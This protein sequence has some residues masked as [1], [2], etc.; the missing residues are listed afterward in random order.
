MWNWQLRTR[1]WYLHH[2]HAG[3]T[4]VLHYS[5]DIMGMIASQITSLTIVYSTIYSDADQRKHQS[6]ASLAFVWGIHRGQMASNAENISIW[7][8][9]H[10]TKPSKWY[11][12]WSHHWF[13]E[14]VVSVVSLSHWVWHEMEALWKIKILF[15]SYNII[16]CIFSKTSFGCVPKGTKWL[17]F[18]RRYIR[19]HFRD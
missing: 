13:S 4:M 7:W 8:R 18:R 2:Q 15:I 14:Q 12:P 17:P 6:S 11:V 1:L 5:D 16:C 9:H 3:E 10:G 19:M